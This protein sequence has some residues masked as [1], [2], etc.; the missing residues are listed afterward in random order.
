MTYT[1]KNTRPEDMPVRF[2][3]SASVP[4]V[5]PSQHIDGRTLMDGG[6]VWNS[7]LQAAINRCHEIVENDAD[8]VLDVIICNDNKMDT[9]NATGNT[10]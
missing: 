7:N 8:I 4:F 9:L 1:E 3:A 5:F 10:V 6:T 2:L